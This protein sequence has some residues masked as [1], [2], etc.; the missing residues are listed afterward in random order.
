MRRSA[1]RSRTQSRKMPATTHAP[2]GKSSAERRGAPVFAYVRADRSPIFERGVI[3]RPDLVLVADETIV[4]V[5]A[6]G[7]LVGLDAHLLQHAD[8]DVAQRGIVVRTERQVLPMAK[9]TA[10]EDDR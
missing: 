9:P 5:P 8:K 1:V 3:T 10:R 4:P 2:A 6:A 7:V